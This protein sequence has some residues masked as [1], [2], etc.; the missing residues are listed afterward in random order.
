MKIAITGHDGFIGKHLTNTLIYKLNYD[1]DDIALINKDDFLDDN[2]L[3]DKLLNSN[4]IIHLAGVNR[5]D[6][7]KYLY[8]ENIRICES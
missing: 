8:N 6:N 2:I 1:L 4:I 3:S 7:L 5:H